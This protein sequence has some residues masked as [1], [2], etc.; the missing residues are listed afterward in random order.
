M[1]SLGEVDA[2]A[3]G[4]FDVVTDADLLAQ[5]MIS[6]GIRAQFPDHQI[7]AEEGY[8]RGP[9]SLDEFCWV[10]DPLDG[11]LNFALGIPCTSVSVALLH[12][13]EPMLGCVYDPVRGELFEAQRG[14]GSSVNG[15]RLA[16]RPGTSALMP[17]GLSSG[18]LSRIPAV[19]EVSLLAVIMR[20][21]AKVRILGSQALHLCYVAAGRLQAAISWEA[22]L[23]DDAAGA[24]IV[25]EAGGQYTDFA[26]NKVFPLRAGSRALAGSAIHSIAASQPAHREL[27]SVLGDLYSRSESAEE[28]VD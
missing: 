2:I 21:F 20:R 3:K 22:R 13:G 25:K 14:A 18:I 15:G 9:A 8:E 17:L 28:N 12:Q 10:I 16:V 1:E 19:G 26:G 5:E 4:S 23:W 7:L 11:T 27:V 6:D 24:L